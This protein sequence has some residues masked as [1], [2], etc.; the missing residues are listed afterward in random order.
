MPRRQS[1]EGEFSFKQPKRFQSA[2]GKFKKGSHW[3][4]KKPHWDREWMVEEYVN[5]KKSASE[6]AL[7]V[8]V[9]ENAIHFWLHK[10]GIPRRTV[11][12]ARSVKHWGAEGE[13]NP[14]FGKKGALSPNWRGGITPERIAFYATIEW[15][16]A[17][18]K[19][20]KRD[21]LTCQICNTH[22]DQLKC[23][24]EIHHIE[25]FSVV[26]KRA[27]VDNLVLLCEE[28]HD[29]VHSRQNIARIYLLGDNK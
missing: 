12:E 25:S 1:R 3:R 17:K 18:R 20:R 23:K 5:K 16:R 21:N 9:T 6:I 2:N 4:E 27:D 29:F 14:M 15:R 11:S 26:E 10:H 7:I 8:G 13:A 19:V 22:R 24:L 28:C